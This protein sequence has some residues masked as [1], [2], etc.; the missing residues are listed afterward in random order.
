MAGLF[1]SFEGIDRSG[2][3]TQARMLVDALG[4]EA[5]PVR[6]PGGTQV[7]EEVRALLKHPSG[8]LGPHAEALLFAAARAELCRQVIRP[9]LARGRVV[10]SDRFLDSSLAYQGDARGLGVD[11]VLEINRWATEGLLPDLTILLTITP[12]DAARRVG[13][14][15]RFEGEGRG[16]QERVRDAYERLAEAEPGRFKRV[17]ANRSADEV[18]AEVIALVGAARSAVSAA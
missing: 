7:G 11:E 12:A 9:A 8:E 16:L 3:T 13:E 4:E 15:D 1:V 5:V 18:H 6:E 14:V 17:E 2:K 10:V